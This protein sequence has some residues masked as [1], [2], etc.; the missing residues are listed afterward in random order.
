MSDFAYRTYNNED[1]VWARDLTSLALIYPSIAAATLHA[2]M[3]RAADDIN[4]VHDWSAANRNLAY[5]DMPATGYF[6]FSANPSPADT[7]T[8]GTT[9]I[10][11]VSSSPGANKALIGAD[12]DATLATL[13]ELLNGSAD[14]QIALCSYT[15]SDDAVVVQFKTVGSAGNTFAIAAASDVIAPSS[16]TLTN[17][18]KGIVLTATAQ[19]VNDYV[20]EYAVD[21]RLESGVSRVRL[22]GGTFTFV[23]GVTR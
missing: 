17:G 13:I 4:V 14:T 20:G 12:L 8:L 9:T 10:T 7:V 19:E 18:G 1:F 22:I 3:R 23:N 2:E 6:S 5:T 15:Q 21:L 11:F 16:A